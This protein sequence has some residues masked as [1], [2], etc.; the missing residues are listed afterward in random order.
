MKRILKGKDQCVDIEAGSDA[1]I[2]FFTNRSDTN[3]FHTEMADTDPIL[4][5]YYCL[6]EIHNMLL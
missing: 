4:G 3:T 2:P 5:A 1:P 6:Q